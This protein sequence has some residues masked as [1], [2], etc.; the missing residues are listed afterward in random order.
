MATDINRAPIDDMITDPAGRVLM[1]HSDT[2]D[3]RWAFPVDAR[4]IMSM[5]PAWVF[6]SKANPLPPK[7]AVVASPTQPKPSVA[8]A[9]ASKDPALPQPAEQSAVPEPNKARAGAIRGGTK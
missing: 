6:A 9:V 2:R 1:I 7:K 5:A 3:E 4:E 8:E